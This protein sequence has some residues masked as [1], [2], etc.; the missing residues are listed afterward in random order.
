MDTVYILL[1]PSNAQPA[2]CHR[3]QT[4]AAV[5]YDVVTIADQG[6]TTLGHGTYCERC[7]DEDN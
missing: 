1:E 2:W 3:C 7:D 4:S 6:V 5:D